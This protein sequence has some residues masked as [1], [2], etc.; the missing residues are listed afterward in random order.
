MAFAMVAVSVALSGWA[1][2]GAVAQE[3]TQVRPVAVA[4]VVGV[5]TDRNA[6]TTTVELDGSRSFD[7]DGDIVSYEWEVVTESL[8]GIPITPSPADEANGIPAGRTAT[9]VIFTRA[10]VR[11]KVESIEFRLTVT[12]NG[13]PEASRSTTVSASINHDPTAVIT[14]SAKLPAPRGQEVA[15]YDDNGNGLVD[16]NEERYTVEG[17]IHAPGEGGNRD[18]EW[19]IREGSLLVVDGSASYDPDGPL[20]DSAFRWERFCASDVASVTATLPDSTDGQKTLSTDENPD[21]VGSIRSE[22]VGRLPFVRGDIADPYFLCYRLTVT[23]EHG[24][25]AQQIVKIVIRDAHAAPTVEIEL[26][27]TDPNPSTTEDRL[28]GIQAAG[29]NRYVISPEVAEDG[30]TLIAVGAADGTARTRVL[31]H[32]W[33]GQ[34]VEPDDDNRPGSRTTALFTAPQGVQQGE[35]FTV[36][37]EVADPADHT[38]STSVELVVADNLPPEAAAPEDIDTPDG[39][40]GGFPD[41]DP[42]SGVVVLEGLGFDPDGFELDYRW[43]Q[44]LNA[45]G[46]PLTLAYRG[47]RLSLAGAGT[48]TAQFTLPEVTRG[49]QY[50]VYIQL[51][52]TD[53]WGVSDTDIVRITIRDGDDDLRAVPGPD[54][55]VSPGSFVRL[56]GRTST[57][58]VSEEA[59]GAVTYQWAFT[60]IETHPRTEDRPQITQAEA[61]EGF[62]LGEWFPNADG[63]YHPTAGGRL[64]S[65]SGR[66]PYFDAPRLYGF[67]SVKLVF[68]LTVGNVPGQQDHTDT[69]IVTVVNGYFSGL[70][71]GPDYCANRSLGGPETYP[72]DSNGDGVADI[73]VLSSTRRATIARLNALERLAVLNPDE[74]RNALHGPP[75]I[76]ATPDTDE[77]DPSLG[78]CIGAP[79]D[80]PGDTATSLAADACGP[81]G[82]DERRL[83]SLPD[84]L[85]PAKAARFFSGPVI[86]GPYFCIN[87]SLGGTRLH[88]FDRDD[89][90]VADICSL[91]HTRRAA[92]ARQDALEAAFTADHPQYHAAL[93]A[94]CAALGTL[95]FGDHPTALAQ[96]ECSR[97]GPAP[98]PGQPL[99]T[100]N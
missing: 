17:V 18:F 30:I 9:F 10:L 44:V 37:V 21:A 96:D 63:T 13:F 2:L 52:V 5:T 89:D 82:A 24:A 77:S 41:T 6:G 35:S 86:T 14:V 38:G 50:V 95:D 65:V 26:S 43:E 53:R 88:A 67:N 74:Y 20:P 7:I 73:C 57:G 29:E 66:Y 3:Q 92:V 15:G 84:P 81:E 97:P 31:E 4:T 58:L 39:N 40:N 48:R 79:M 51:T 62:V 55:R 69:V 56:Q 75:D 68:S 45:S 33:S 42:P 76:P 99:P 49:S 32:T 64:K 71:E 60:G 94:A 46:R 87:F 47:P 54:Q 25:S 34:G 8:A 1:V 36:T 90:G 98:D 61:A 59:L 100:A 12:D 70:I 78:T 11:E 27:A 91:A 22:T 28:A 16:E 23:D 93:A 85:D 19:D 80:L 72:M 83:P